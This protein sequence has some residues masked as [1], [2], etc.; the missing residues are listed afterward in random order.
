[1]PSASRPQWRLSWGTGVAATAILMLAAALGVLVPG[2]PDASWLPAAL[3]E[4]VQREPGALEGSTE[5]PV[6]RVVEAIGQGGGRL[7]GSLGKVTYV[8]RCALRGGAGQ[9]LVVETARGKVTVVLMPG[10]PLASRT[11]LTRDGLTSVVLPAGRGSVG[12]VAGSPEAL[13]EVA[14]A[15]RRGIAWR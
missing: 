6:A 15:I 12:I 1:M 9:H 8:G 5:V 2:R 14:E 4:H 13:S 7:L 11:E 10:Q 3:I